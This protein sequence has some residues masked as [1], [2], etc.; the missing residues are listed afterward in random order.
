MAQLYS[1]LSALNLC[2]AATLFQY[3]SEIF[4]RNQIK[5]NTLVISLHVQQ[6]K[7]IFAKKEFNMLPDHYK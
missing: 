6:F 7:P 3:L 5:D 4:H 2:I 1:E